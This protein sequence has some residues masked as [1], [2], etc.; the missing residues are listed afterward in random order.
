M[1]QEIYEIVIDCICVIAIDSVLA[2]LMCSRQFCGGRAG[3]C[4]STTLI[5]RVLD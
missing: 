3:G 5:I 4:S 2:D 1:N